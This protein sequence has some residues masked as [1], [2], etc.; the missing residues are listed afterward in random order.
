MLYVQALCLASL[1]LERD[2]MGARRLA[3]PPPATLLTPACNASPPACNPTCPAYVATNPDAYDVV[4]GHRCPGNGCFVAAVSTAAGRAPDAVCGKPAADLASYLVSAY[5]LDPLQSAPCGKCRLGECRVPQLA[6]VSV[7]GNS[8]G[9]WLRALRS[10]DEPPSRPGWAAARPC[11]RVKVAESAASNPQADLH[12]WR[13]AG[14]R[15]RAGTCNGQFVAAG[16][17]GRR[18]SR[19]PAH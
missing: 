18:N 2:D 4:A 10:R 15:Y 12:G 9:S 3:E 19:R 13:S 6:T 8:P 14:H 5:G 17:H 7:G 11:G 1:F 16:V